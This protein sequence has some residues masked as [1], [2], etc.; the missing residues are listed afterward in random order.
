MRTCWA[1]AFPLD[2]A[3]CHRPL[4]AIARRLVPFTSR[5][6]GHQKPLLH[7][8]E[9]R[10]PRPQEAIRGACTMSSRIVADKQ[11]RA[12]HHPAK[13]QDTRRWAKTMPSSTGNAARR[14]IEVALSSQPSRPCMAIGFSNQ[15]GT[16]V[17]WPSARTADCWGSTPGIALNKNPDMERRYKQP[18]PPFAPC[19]CHPGDIV[20]SHN[21]SPVRAVLPAGQC[22]RE[23][24]HR[25]G[26]RRLT[27]RPRWLQSQRWLMRGRPRAWCFARTTT[28][29]VDVHHR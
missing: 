24:G 26:R 18:W 4:Q 15:T 16:P 5:W 12:C 22:E 14:Q 27:S 13:T 28:A 29:G 21:A 1:V 9:R 6:F 8:R 20:T 3:S 25:H 19:V 2:G 7:T 11:S 10:D 23:A 17:I